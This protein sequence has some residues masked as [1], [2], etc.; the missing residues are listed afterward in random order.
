[1]TAEGIIEALHG[2]HGVC[3]CPAHDDRS[4]SLSIRERGGK[5]LV[6][7]HAGCPQSDVIEALRARGL[8]PERERP[9]WTPTE[10]Q[11]WGRRRHAAERLGNDA[12]AWLQIRV[13]HLEDEKRGAYEANDWNR[14]APAARE[15]YLFG[16]RGPGWVIG[17][18]QAAQRADPRGTAAMVRA[19]REMAAAWE[20]VV[21]MMIDAMANREE[22]AP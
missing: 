7:C 10:R 14:L 19:G 3:R 8:W 20:R 21:R 5:V 13:E 18:Y 4:P 6:H 9:Q 15:L 22:Q 11:A 17:A 16:S 2:H 1:M 12:A